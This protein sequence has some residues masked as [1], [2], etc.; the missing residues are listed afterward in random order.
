M[1]KFSYLFLSEQKLQ[2]FISDVTPYKKI[3]PIYVTSHAE[4]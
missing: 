3:V 2:K 4:H 1:V